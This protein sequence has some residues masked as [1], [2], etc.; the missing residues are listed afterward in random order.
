MY[1]SKSSLHQSPLN[2]KREKEKKRLKKKKKK[3]KKKNKRT[4]EQR[5]EREREKKKT[6]KIERR[7][8]IPSSIVFN[9]KN[10]TPIKLT[11]SY[12]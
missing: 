4:K 5:R 3:K 12:K 6:C 2:S 9:R 1:E 8:N 10:S 7:R 11:S